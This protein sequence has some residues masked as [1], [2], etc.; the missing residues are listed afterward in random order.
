MARGS[1]FSPATKADCFQ[2]YLSTNMSL[3]DIAGKFGV[4]SP[5]I[6]KWSSDGKWADVRRDL[7]REG[8]QQ[9][10]SECLA[11]IKQ[12]RKAV[13]E[14]HLGAASVVEDTV[15]LVAQRIQ[16]QV[17]RLDAHAAI[18]ET[19]VRKLL[20]LA[21]ALDSSGKVSSRAVGMESRS[22]GMRSLQ[23]NDNALVQINLTPG[24]RKL[25]AHRQ[26]TIEAQTVSDPDW[27]EPF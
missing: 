18:S 13:L 8:M 14:R 6:M 2:A 20:D 4:S 25:Q 23:D 10:M 11:L 1:S 7:E 9:V 5:T 19:T 26:L 17:E 27:E 3:T 12:N 21:R 16:A 15:R 22:G 24:N